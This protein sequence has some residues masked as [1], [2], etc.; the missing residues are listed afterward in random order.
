MRVVILHNAVAADAS[1]DDQD[2]LTQA[3]AVATALKR[4]GHE[5]AMFSC[6]LDLEKM[7]AELVR[8][9]PD[10][11]FNLVESL[12]GSDLLGCLPAAVLEVFQIRYTGAPAEVLFITTHKLL[13]KQRL[14]ACGLPTPDW[15]EYDK[16]GKLVPQGP[17]LE[18]VFSRKESW[19]I[20]GVW[21]HGSRGLEDDAVLR[22]ATG[23]HLRAALQRRTSAEAGP[24]YAERYI[25]GREFVV[26]L[27]A[28]PQGP[29]TLPPAEIEFRGFPPEKPR[30]VGYRAKWEEECFECRHTIRR[31]S[32]PLADRPLLDCLTHLTQKCWEAF[33]LRGWCRVDFRVDDSGRPWILEVNANPCISP[34]AGFAAMLKEAAIPYKEAIRRILEDT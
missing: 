19:I 23:E 31:F 8:L 30:I 5:A 17:S 33:G 13:A 3:A 29:E 34:D 16:S 27:L 20:K 10:V 12:G 1:P 6:T 32:F 22:E 2:T 11:V 14:R 26:G 25:E 7:L 21:S 28:G 18:N 9:K 15:V 24:C 4:L